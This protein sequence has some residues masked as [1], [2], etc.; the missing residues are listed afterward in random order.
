MKTKKGISL[1]T[2]VI[3][4]I[5]I[6]ILA[7]I[8]IVSI[9]KNNPI[10]AANEAL[11]KEN[12]DSFQS[13]L[14]MYHINNYSKSLGQ[15]EEDKLQADN[16]KV[17]YTGVGQVETEG[18]TIK[19]I[20]TGLNSKKYENEF[21][22]VNGK[23]AYKGTDATK[24]QWSSDI[25]ILVD[26]DKTNVT[27]A[28][29]SI[30]PIKQTG[31]IEYTI[32]VY[33]NVGIKDISDITNSIK[34]IDKDSNEVT[35]TVTVGQIKSLTNEKQIPVTIQGI[36]LADGEYKVKL[37][38][39]AVEKNTNLK[40][41][42][43]ISINS[44]TVDSTAPTNPKIASSPTTLTNQ[45]V[46]ATITYPVDSVT[47][48]YSYNG[49]N[50]QTYTTA[51]TISSNCTVYARAIDVA[52][53]ISGQA[54]LSISNIDK[55]NPT[56]S[57]L[58]NG[59]NNVKK[60]E[61]TVIVTDNSNEFSSL[62]YIWTT[63][64][65]EPT[66]GWITFENNAKL[67]KDTVTASYYLWI[68]ATDVAGNIT[69]VKSEAFGIDNTVPEAPGIVPSTTNWT[70]QNITVTITYPSDS[71]KNEYSYDGI[72]WSNYTTALTISSN[73]V[74]YARATDTAGN[75]S[76]SS[77]LSITNIDKIV[78]QNTTISASLSDAV[79]SAI[80]TFQDNESGIDLSKSK[81]IVSQVSTIYDIN[82]SI[83]NSASTIT[84]NPRK[85]NY[86]AATS[87]NYYLQTLSVDN[88]GNKLVTISGNIAVVVNSYSKSGLPVS[89]GS[90]GTALSE[91]STIDGQTPSYKDPVIPAGFFAVNTSSA[92]WN[93]YSTNW[94]NGLVIQDNFGNQF[95]WVPVNGSY[96]K[97]PSFPSNLSNS[98]LSNLVDD[99][100]PES[101]SE[102]GLVNK[103]G[104]FYIGRC[105]AGFNY[106]N[107]N[108]RA[109]SNK[110]KFYAT[111]NWSSN[112]VAKDDNYQWN[113]I[114]YTD[115]KRY[116]ENMD[117]AYNYYTNKVGT[118]LV[119]GTEWDMT[120]KWLQSKG[121]NIT[122]DSSS[123]GNYLN[124]EF[125]YTRS[126]NSR[127]K[128]ANIDELSC[129]GTSTRNCSNNIYD[130]AGNELEWT[131]EIYLGLSISG[132]YVRIYRGGSYKENGSDSPASKRLSNKLDY[133]SKAVGFRVAVYVK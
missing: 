61:T 122:S 105:E 128:L 3:T 18:K 88:A 46:T 119:T 104:G 50:W 116:A 21:E 75:I 55:E 109:M 96:Q 62:Q 23:L 38:A 2:L 9:T 69:T 5:V 86:T 53:N 103:Y 117:T 58:P 91:N 79:I 74:I 80:V 35:A 123:W 127:T 51:L 125:I 27:I 126:N 92:D 16:T 73:C 90:I 82:D 106:N 22:I 113:W 97:N 39:G 49:T 130:L 68:K 59:Q 41:V 64:T 11:F 111:T 67:N 33:S 110:C 115:A 6:I 107:G 60:A 85:I 36:G 47:N 57:F 132:E 99:T 120:M 37:L 8:I 95:V 1:M 7:G 100:F 54:T 77:T 108:I 40:N 81:Y 32:D 20:I 45:D 28:T 84:T 24:Q 131:N 121:Y 76:S 78:P 65:T 52:K 112:R 10:N 71:I 114:N 30:L 98:T 25:G 26:N 31:S 93:N 89:E 102:T 63:N 14:S 66:D 43:V 70:N 101:L 48:E 72:T 118:N 94:N 34:V 15:Y 4:I 124:T 29:S 19:D 12:I 17:Q 87:G 83:W 13:E 56:V 133:T 129:T 42:D 44:F